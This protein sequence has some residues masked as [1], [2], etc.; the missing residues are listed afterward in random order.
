MQ[1]L[2]DSRQSI[3]HVLPPPETDPQIMLTTKGL[4]Q[5]FVGFLT[6]PADEEQIPLAAC[7]SSSGLQPVPISI[8][9]GALNVLEGK[10]EVDLLTFH[11]QEL[12][13]VLCS[14]NV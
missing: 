13:F 6:W 5:T 1:C 12:H 9:E 8:L 2:I 14:G 10:K 11:L 3:I 4:I 7:L